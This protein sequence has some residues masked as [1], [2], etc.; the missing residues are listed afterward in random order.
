MGSKDYEYI[1]LL[2]HLYIHCHTLFSNHSSLLKA[3]MVKFKWDV[4]PY[5]QNKEAHLWGKG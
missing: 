5:C 2:V 4:I 1:Y 3:S